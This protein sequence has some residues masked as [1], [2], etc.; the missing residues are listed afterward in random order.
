M[1]TD[2]LAFHPLPSTWRFWSSLNPKLCPGSLSRFCS[3]ISPRKSMPLS[4][5][6]NQKSFRI[7]QRKSKMYADLSL[8]LKLP[9]R[10]GHNWQNSWKDLGLSSGEEG[11]KVFLLKRNLSLGRVPF[12]CLNDSNSR[13]RMFS[14][15]ESFL[16]FRGEGKVSAKLF[17]P[18]SPRCTYTAHGSI[19]CIVVREWQIEFPVLSTF[20]ILREKTFVSRAKGNMIYC[21]GDENQFAFLLLHGKVWRKWIS[22]TAQK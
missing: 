12:S 3:P 6:K 15:F 9:S 11:K 8:P 16:F 18:F 17:L 4:V 21:E 2:S 22:H 19:C 1:N 20:L 10:L 14:H 13:T 7:A 5:T